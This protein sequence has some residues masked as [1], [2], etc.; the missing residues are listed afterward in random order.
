M[1]P[2]WICSDKITNE[3][4][5]RVGDNHFISNKEE[6]NNCFSKF[7]NRVLPSIFI[8]TI[9][10]SVRKENYFP[11]DVKFRLLAHS[12]RFLANQKA[13]NA[14]VGAENLLNLDIAAFQNFKVFLYLPHA[15]EDFGPSRPKSKQK[16][17]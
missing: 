11:Y 5:A 9:L 17:N 13:R 1:S 3:R 12:R 16:K 4:V 10:Q 6:W 8:S 2:S 15:C 14:I 7:S